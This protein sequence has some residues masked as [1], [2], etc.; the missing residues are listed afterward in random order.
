MVAMQNSMVEM[1]NSPYINTNI[2][3]VK[4]IPVKMSLYKL[5]D[6]FMLPPKGLPLWSRTKSSSMM[7]SEI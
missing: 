3:A 7:A 2:P 5:F 6:L 4:V 1:M